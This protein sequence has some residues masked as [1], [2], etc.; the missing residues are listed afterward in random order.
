MEKPNEWRHDGGRWRA[1]T[2]NEWEKKANAKFAGEEA[3]KTKKVR[4]NNLENRKLH[5][6]ETWEREAGIIEGW[7][8]QVE[9]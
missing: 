7:C 9:V 5:S 4:E 6:M 1:I 2:S 3:G 8:E